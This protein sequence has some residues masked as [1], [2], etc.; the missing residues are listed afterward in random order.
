ML[1]WYQPVSQD[2]F[3]WLDY[4]GD[5]QVAVDGGCVQT[6]LGG[7][8]AQVGW[9]DTK[10]GGLIFVKSEKSNMAGWHWKIPLLNQWSIPLLNGHH[11]EAGAGFSSSFLQ[12][13]PIDALVVI[14]SLDEVMHIL[15]L[16][17]NADWKLTLKLRHIFSTESVG[18]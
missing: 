12:N 2:L 14:P 1:P 4:D 17:S 8:N 6:W 15:L 7:T 9:L 18:P 11:A 10:G 5:G 3:T 16:F 13:L